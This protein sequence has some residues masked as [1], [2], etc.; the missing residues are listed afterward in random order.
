MIRT[1]IKLSQHHI[2]SSC[3]VCKQDIWYD[4]P[5]LPLHCALCLCSLCKERLPFNFS[6]VLCKNTNVLL[7]PDPLTIE[8]NHSWSIIFL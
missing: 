8:C 5:T 2:I 6:P 4:G 7:F 3:Y 1:K